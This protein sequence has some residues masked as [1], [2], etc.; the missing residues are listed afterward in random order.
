[1]LTVPPEKNPD[2]SAWRPAV[3][4]EAVYVHIPFCRQR[5]GYCNFSVVAGRD[6]LVQRFLDALE[7]EIGWLD[8]S[9]RLKTLFLGGGTPS[10]LA[11]GELKQLK[12]ILQTRFSFD[13]TT[14]FTAECNPNDLDEEKCETLAELGVN[15]ISLGI[16]SL[17]SQK[18]QQLERTHTP[19]QVFRAVENARRFARSVSFDLIFAAPGET[20]DNWRR[21]LKAALELHPDHL[22]TYELTYEKGTPF[23]NLRLHQSLMEADEDLRTK[24]YDQAIEQI[25]S[26]GLVQYEI[27]SFARPGHQCLHN[28]VYWLGESYFAFGPGAARYIDGGRQSNHQSTMHYLKSIEQG[29]LPVA[30][31]ERLSPL[32]SAKELLSIGLRRVAG[33]D[34]S[35][36]EARTGFSALELTGK[37][38]EVWLEQGLMNLDQGLLKLTRGGRMVAD[39][40]ATRI[41]TQ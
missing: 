26:A 27:S 14:E 23:W 37:Y 6:Y 2:F 8:R 7:T 36:F 33:I 4:P 32:E 21:D 9:Y 38:T 15:R 35:R 24:M 20:F 18:L 31:S 30:I 28:E 19:E 16:Q 41:L 13:Q 25:E 12:R 39:W 22:S 3:A 1:M 29:A 5:C 17:D 11:P 40:I 10:H 34:L